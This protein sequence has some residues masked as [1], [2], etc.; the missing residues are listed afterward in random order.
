M[1]NLCYNCGSKVVEKT[2]ELEKNFNGRI[3]FISDVPVMVCEECGESYVDRPILNK[4]EAMLKA[5]GSAGANHFSY[6]DVP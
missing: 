3:Y 2:T 1:M 6:R 4:V 5:G